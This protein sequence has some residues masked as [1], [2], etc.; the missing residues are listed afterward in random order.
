MSAD[1]P[2][3]YLIFIFLKE[4]NNKMVHKYY[5]R[6]DP[7]YCKSANFGENF[8]FTKSVKRYICDIQNTRQ[9]HDLPISVIDSA[10]SLGFDF[11][12]TSHAKF[13]ENKILAK[14]SEFTVYSFILKLIFKHPNE[15]PQQM[16]SYR[17]RI[18][19]I[20]IPFCF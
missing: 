16:Y 9:G 1:F 4:Q 18:I 3:C 6:S 15:N 14:I 10:I 19:V 12:E 8:I 11:H 5:C 7:P 2:F 20:W 17:I 13:R